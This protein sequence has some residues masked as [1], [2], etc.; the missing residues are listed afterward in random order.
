LYD[1]SARHPHLLISLLGDRYGTP[2]LDRCVV[3]KAA[4]ALAG[5]RVS[6]Q[7]TCRPDHWS[8]VVHEQSMNFSQVSVGCATTELNSRRSITNSSQL[9]CGGSGRSATSIEQPI[10]DIFRL[11]QVRIAFGHPAK[12]A[13]F[14]SEITE[15]AW[16][17]DPLENEIP[18]QLMC[19]ASESWSKS[20][21]LE[22]G[23]SDACEHDSLLFEIAAADS[24]SCDRSS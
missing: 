20:F 17:P 9:L 2:R 3:S 6:L 21:R 15:S 14:T 23:K 1:A 19:L 22:I 4:S 12:D 8:T 5:G 16:C 7:E 18:V 10:S 11:D 13:I 24:F